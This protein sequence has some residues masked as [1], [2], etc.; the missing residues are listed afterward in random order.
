VNGIV[1][2]AAQQPVAGARVGGG[3]SLTTTDIY[4]KF[5]LTDVP[6]GRYPIVAVSDALGSRGEVTVDIVQ[7]GQV[8]NAAI[9]LAAV[10]AI[11]GNAVQA[12]GLTPVPNADVYVFSREAGA[13]SIVGTGKTDANGGF[14]ILSIP[15][16]S[17]Q[18]SA[19][20]ASFTDGNIVPATVRFQ[21]ETFRT[22]IRFRGAGGKI[23]GRVLDDDGQTPLKA[24]VA[25]SGDQLVVAGNKVGVEFTSTTSGRGHG[26]PTGAYIQQPVGRA[27]D[28]ERRR[29]VQP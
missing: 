16:G 14:K 19:F 2:D 15:A 6:V 27:G 28:G 1:R 22:T 12:D 9:T 3:L 13:I 23:T 20:N 29:P 5:T 7:A 21:G 4:G 26:L 18:V 8:V 25:V 11:S 17:Y 24:R 10:G